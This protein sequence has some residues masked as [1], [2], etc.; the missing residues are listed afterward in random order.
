MTLWGSSQGGGGAKQRPRGLR[1]SGAIR[2]HQLLPVLA[3]AEQSSSPRAGMGSDQEDSKPITLGESGEGE[4]WWARPI[5]IFY[6]G[7]IF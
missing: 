5:L 3:D 7:I 2:Y 6:L 1:S 4:G